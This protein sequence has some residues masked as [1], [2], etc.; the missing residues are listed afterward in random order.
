[1]CRVVNN[2]SDKPDG[3]KSYH[4]DTLIADVV[5]LLDALK[6]DQ[7]VLMVLGYYAV[8]TKKRAPTH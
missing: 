4:I 5:A 8:I 6:I 2:L 3:V 7:L 1:M